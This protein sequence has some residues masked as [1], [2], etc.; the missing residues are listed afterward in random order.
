MMVENVRTIATVL[1]GDASALD[2]FDVGDTWI[3]F[4]EFSSLVSEE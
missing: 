2:G 1:G 3:S 4:V